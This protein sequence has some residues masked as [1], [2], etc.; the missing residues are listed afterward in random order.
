M[1]ITTDELHDSSDFTSGGKL[2]DF[3]FLVLDLLL[4]SDV[5]VGIRNKDSTLMFTLQRN[6]ADGIL[7]RSADIYGRKF[8]EF[9]ETSLETIEGFEYLNVGNVRADMMTQDRDN[10]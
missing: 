9:Y 6:M 4:F 5:K 3:L 8:K 10:R 2:L 1:F 7:Q